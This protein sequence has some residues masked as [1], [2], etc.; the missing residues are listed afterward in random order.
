M[1][2]D[3]QRS[4]K[5]FAKLN[6]LLTRVKARP[7]PENVHQ[8]RTTTRRVEALLKAMPADGERGQRKLL[9]QLKRLRRRAG[10]LR[11]LDVQMAALRTLKIERDAARKSQLMQALARRRTRRESKLVRDLDAATVRDLRKRLRRAAAEHLAPPPPTAEPAAAETAPPASTPPD[12]E[13][14]PL[15]LRNFAQLARQTGP[16]TDA[17][18]HQFRTRG[19][20]VRYLAEMAGEDP[21]ARRVVVELKR[22]QDAIGDWHDWFTLTQEAE[23]L[24]PDS[25]DGALVAALRNVTRAKFMEALRTAAEAKR[26]LLSLPRRAGT[27]RGGGK[28]GRKPAAPPRPKP[29]IAPPPA[30]AAQAATA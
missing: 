12:L 26:I 11:D 9:R 23:E 7:Q 8:L 14:L 30:D 18:L 15:A 13:P 22:M 4:Q 25:R 28:P 1:P 24:Y 6:R 29:A 21:R 3:Y 5:L 2:V 16:L 17:N 10:N 27:R 20:R 19:K